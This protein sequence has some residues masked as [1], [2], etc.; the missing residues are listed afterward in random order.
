MGATHHLSPDTS[1]EKAPLSHPA[2]SPRKV[3]PTERKSR[4]GSLPSPPASDERKRASTADELPQRL[5]E[6]K[7]KCR[8]GDYSP[9]TELHLSKADYSRL[10]DKL[11]ATFRRFDYNPRRQLISIRMPSTVHDLFISLFSS[12]IVSKIREIGLQNRRARAFTESINNGMSSTVTLID[13]DDKWVQ[14][15]DAQFR[16]IKA[17]YSGVVVEVALT[18][19]VKRL[20]R[21][22]RRYIHHTDGQIKVVLCID[23]NEDKES[24]ISV[25]KPTFS[26]AQDSDEVDMDMDIE[27]VVRSQPF[28][29]AEKNPVDGLLTL[30]L[31]D[32]APDHLC[33]GCPN[34]PFSIPYRDMS[35]ML[36][37]AE[38][39]KL[40]EERNEM[41]QS[42]IRVRKRRLS[43]SSEDRMAEED[44]KRYSDEADD[45]IDKE[46]RDD[47]AYKPPKNL[48]N[49]T[50]EPRKKLAQGASRGDRS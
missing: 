10:H 5:V 8:T 27:Q 33:H 46:N 29:D 20:R 2:K 34:T 18:Q 47:G 7:R 37:K 23:L 3:T 13:G 31:H 25:W 39:Y 43:E 4:S 24:T 15:P 12:A 11:E 48:G 9:L 30:Q 41:P 14:Q 1:P 21:I 45:A 35:D 50:F 17:R 40:N 19:D 6:F 22:A 42:S 26:P 28:R 44:E 49:M 38:L 32:F 36:I 16:H